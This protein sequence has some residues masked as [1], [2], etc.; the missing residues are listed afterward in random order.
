MKIDDAIETTTRFFNDLIGTLIPGVVLIAGLVVIHHGPIEKLDDYI[1]K[2]GEIFAVIV[3][4]AIL[5]AS[6][7]GLLAV[8]DY[9]AKR[10]W[11]PV[12]GWI[13]KTWPKKTHNGS[14]F[15]RRQSYVVFRA[16]ALEKLRGCVTLDPSITSWK[17][18]TVNDIRS[19][20]LTIS[21]DAAD[22]GRRF[23]FISML[24]MGVGT[25]LL[26]L[27]AD[28]L[29]CLLFAPEFLHQYRFALPP[30]L[31]TILMVALVLSFFDR[32]KSFRDRAMWTPFPVAIADI[33]L[34]KKEKTAEN[35]DKK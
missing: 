24:C 3:L 25:A 26:I 14:H 35:E 5:F 18:W 9:A 6:G 13:A 20:A 7:H 32:A 31:Q 1:P 22:L 21:K 16:M 19:L 17:D 30:Q 28:Y 27:L 8:N 10:I 12:A 15:E 34:K 11:G 23:M 33:E 4:V 29:V 2:N